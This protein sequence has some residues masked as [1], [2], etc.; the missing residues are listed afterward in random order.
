M[1]H[2]REGSIIKFVLYIPTF[3]SENW[4]N[5]KEITKMEVGVYLAQRQP[6]VLIFVSKF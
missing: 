6:W 4:E 5:M 3:C 1:P 2:I